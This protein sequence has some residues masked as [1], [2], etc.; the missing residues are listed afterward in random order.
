M[1]ESDHGCRVRMT[2]CLPFRARYRPANRSRLLPPR[3]LSLPA[4]LGFVRLV[5]VIVRLPRDLFA[6]KRRRDLGPQH[7]DKDDDG[8]DHEYQGYD[9]GE[10]KDHIHELES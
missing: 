5:T 8:V 3:G 2:I 9:R 10:G 6:T 7:D 1:R 4:I